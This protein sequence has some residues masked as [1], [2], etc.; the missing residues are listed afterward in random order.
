MTNKEAIKTLEANYPDTCF[1]QLREAVDAAIE[2]LK[3][4]DADSDTISRK[5][6]I[7]AILAV[8]GN[9]SVRELY[10]HVQEHGLSEM[11]SGGVNAAI[12]III[13]VPSAQPEQTNSWCINS[14]CINCKEYDKEKHS[15]PRFNRVIKQTLDDAY[16]HGETEAEARFHAQQRWIPCSERLPEQP[17]PNPELEG[18]PLDIYLV[19]K[20][21]N[22][23][24]RAFWNGR[25]FADGWTTLDVDAWM[26]LPEPYQAERRTDE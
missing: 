2:A 13:A 19:C 11:W 3:A 14:W 8:T 5:A 7:D 18:K 12:D 20:Q 22:I 15:C 26:P 4:Q 16:R 23:P 6:A 9:S 10:E 25:N 24:F 21:G 1:E 17:N